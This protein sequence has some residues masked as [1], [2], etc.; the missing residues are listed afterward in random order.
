VNGA[1]FAHVI[2]EIMRADR[3]TDK[4]RHV[5]HSILHSPTGGKVMKE[6]R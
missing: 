5:D 3:H 2:F 6:L 4:H 1:K